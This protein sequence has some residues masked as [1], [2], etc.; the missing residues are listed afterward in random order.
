M[1]DFLKSFRAPGQE[2][3]D[4]SKLYIYR[5][6]PKRVVVITLLE[7]RIVDHPEIIG[8][9]SRFFRKYDRLV[10]VTDQPEFLHLR[11]TG[12]AFEY[13]PSLLQQSLYADAMP[14]PSYL[15]SRW[16]LILAKW[17]PECV[18]AYG[19]NIDRFLDA[20]AATASKPECPR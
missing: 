7:V 5:S 17:R 19:M 20:A 12:A 14:W 1:I 18:L 16:E 13:L 9:V 6:A 10:Y 11:E 15:K 8:K 4:Q 3:P 2:T